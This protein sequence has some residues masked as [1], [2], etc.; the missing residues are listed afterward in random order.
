MAIRTPL[1]LANGKTQ[2]LKTVDNLAIRKV[3]LDTALTAEIDG[4]ANIANFLFVEISAAA[5]DV[6]FGYYNLNA[7][8]GSFNITLDST[9][10]IGSSWI[11]ADPNQT[12]G[13]NTVSVANVGAT[14]TDPTGAYVSGVF[15]IDSAGAA[16][17]VYKSGANQ[18]DIVPLSTGS[19]DLTSYQLRN[20]KGIA[21]GY[22]SLDASGFVPEIQLPTKPYGGYSWAGV[23]TNTLI[24]TGTVFQVSTQTTDP[25]GTLNEF[26]HSNNRLTYT[27]TKTREFKV[28]TSCVVTANSTGAAVYVRIAKNGTTIA[29]SENLTVTSAASRWECLSPQTIVSLATNDYVEIWVSH[30]TNGS[31][32]T[33]R[34]MSLIIEA[35]T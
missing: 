23:Q 3:D 1:V 7:A 29:D 32:V 8:G 12:I 15:T 10:A 33:Q 14:F 16:L 18:Y 21:T 6:V 11:F 4:K 13:A 9:A 2:E 24:T 20:E 27:G 35:L 34:T 22:A 17:I 31:N 19:G 30:G 5:T 26:T 28:Q 25:I